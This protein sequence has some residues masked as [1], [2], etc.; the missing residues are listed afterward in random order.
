LSEDERI[1]DIGAD[2][3]ALSTEFEKMADAT[4]DKIQA[5]VSAMNKNFETLTENIDYLNDI[6][7][8]H[9][10]ELIILRVLVAVFGV[11]IVF[12]LSRV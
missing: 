3:D 10:D 5:V 1:N 7:I 6:M 11:L 2:L 8:S 4:A 12:L 9:H